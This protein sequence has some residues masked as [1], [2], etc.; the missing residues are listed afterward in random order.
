M[1]SPMYVFGSVLKSQM[2]VI[3]TGLYLGRLFLGL[4]AY[5]VFALYQ[6]ITIFLKFLFYFYS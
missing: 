4:L 5:V 6:Y 1:F 3:L 2:F